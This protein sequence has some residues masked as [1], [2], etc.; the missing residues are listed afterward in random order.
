MESFIVLRPILSRY[1]Y[2]YIYIY[3][4]SFFEILVSILTKDG[5]SI[6]WNT[7][8]AV[9]VLYKLVAKKLIPPKH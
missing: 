1:I 6:S 9:L 8:F 4:G 7:I 3:I 5:V 2:I